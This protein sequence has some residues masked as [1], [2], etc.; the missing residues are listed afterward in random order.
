MT[1]T[2]VHVLS[3]WHTR[4]WFFYF[5]LFLIVT[6]DNQRTGIPP[7]KQDLLQN[8]PVIDKQLHVVKPL[9]FKLEVCA[10]TITSLI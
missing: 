3:L 2:G 6:E 10:S 7:K 9:E 4:R 8:R 1:N 5:V